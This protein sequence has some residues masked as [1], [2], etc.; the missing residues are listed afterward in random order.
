MPE[1]MVDKLT[2]VA[3][4]NFPMGA[5]AFFTH[6]IYSICILLNIFHGGLHVQSLACSI[7]VIFF[8]SDIV[9]PN[10]YRLIAQIVQYLRQKK[11]ILYSIGTKSYKYISH[12]YKRSK[13]W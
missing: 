1:K 10:P 2:H 5:L 13:S 8:C 6:R 3:L 9:V 7:Y 4:Y 11:Q 12:Q